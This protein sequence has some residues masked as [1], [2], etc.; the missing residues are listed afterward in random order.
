MRL[1][2]IHEGDIVRV[3]DG[4]PYHAI[5]RERERRQLLV[6]AI[7]RTGFVRTVKAVDITHHWRR[8]LKGRPYP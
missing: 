2:G 7:G 3:D 1:T 6:E 4:L 8:A 5:V